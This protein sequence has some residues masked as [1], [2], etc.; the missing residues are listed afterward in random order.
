MALSPDETCTALGRPR[1]TEADEAIAHAALTLLGETGFEGVTVE[2][3]A[4]R[5]GVA[6]STV[7]RRYPGK[8][9]L[10]VEVIRQ[11]SCAPMVVPDTGTVEGDLV[12]IAEHLRQ[13][14][15]RTDLGRAL[16][17]VVAAAAR[18]PEVAS[19][20]R[21]YVSARRSVVIDAIERGI[22]RGEIDPAVDPELLIDMI[23]GPLFH[24]AFVSRRPIDNA[25]V[26]ELV[27]RALRGAAPRPR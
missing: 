17:A 9:E 24:R 1:S 23:V 21:T 20:H 3:V 25:L 2:A 4:A 18:H 26:V 22:E 6:K 16:P 15:T 14:F 19:A 13:S 12:A 27:S 10:L 8:P 7:Y 5:A 11:A